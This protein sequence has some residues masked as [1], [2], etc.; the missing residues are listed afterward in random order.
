MLSR[1]HDWSACCFHPSNGCIEFWIFN[2]SNWSQ[3]KFEKWGRHALIHMQRRQRTGRDPLVSTALVSLWA[4]SISVCPPSGA[5]TWLPEKFVA[6]V[7]KSVLT[8]V[9][10]CTLFLALRMRNVS[11]VESSWSPLHDFQNFC[12]VLRTVCVWRQLFGEP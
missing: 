12:F 1:S 11:E 7:V 8:C 2:T 3:I 6:A 4:S 10:C 5:L 9:S